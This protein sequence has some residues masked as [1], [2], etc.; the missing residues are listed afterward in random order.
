MTF[1]TVNT[2]TFLQLIVTIIAGAEGSGKMALGQHLS[3]YS[4]DDQNWA[5]I[6]QAVNNTDEFSM[7]N[8]QVRDVDLVTVLQLSPEWYRNR[9]YRMVCTSLQ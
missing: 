8:L 2:C 1:C 4:K 9:S 3:K 5:V 7:R 6:K